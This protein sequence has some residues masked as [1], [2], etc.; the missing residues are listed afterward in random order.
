LTAKR[1][2]LF[3][4]MLPKGRRVTILGDSLTAD[5][6]AEVEA[7]NRSVGVKLQPLEL[8]NPP[9]DFNSVF[10]GVT[11]SGAEALFVLESAPIF[12]G[13]MQIAQLAMKHRLPTSFAFREDV[14][15][16]GVISYGRKVCD[17][18]RRRP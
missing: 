7:A 5:Q 16:G 10:R 4:E 13:R 14:E 8:R 15:A 2:A 12:Q 9:Y 18:W 3:R 11:R 6:L 1:F 17:M